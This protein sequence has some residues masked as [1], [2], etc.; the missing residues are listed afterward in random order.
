MVYPVIPRVLQQFNA[1]YP[2]VKVHLKT[3]YSAGLRAEFGRGD[4]DLIL[5][6]EVQAGPEAE[7][8]VSRPLAWVGAPGGSIWRQR[9]LRVAFE[10]HCSFRPLSLSALDQAGVDWE[11]AVETDSD[12][13]IEATVSA[14]LAVN[15][16]IAGTEPAHLEQIPH[17]GTLPDLPVQLINMY[18]A[19][20]QS[21]P[22]A[23]LPICCGA[24]S[25]H[26]GADWKRSPDR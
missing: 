7:T 17:G 21:P 26:Q 2:R 14:D 1:A 19:P 15:T 13:T 5:T 12:R 4:C 10:R 3:S 18:T 23:E 9:P 8:L 20:T 16:M 25:R 24:G 22:V 6:T 11:A